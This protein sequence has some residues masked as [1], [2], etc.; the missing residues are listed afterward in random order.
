[1]CKPICTVA[2][3]LRKSQKAVYSDHE[4]NK[5]SFLSTKEAH[6]EQQISSE[7]TLAFEAFSTSKN[8]ILS[9]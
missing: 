9:S 1:M 2:H 6:F 4:K 5:K 8:S 3:Q 7:F